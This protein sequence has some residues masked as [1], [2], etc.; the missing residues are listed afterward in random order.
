[1]A[2][3]IPE[4]TI[5]RIK[6]TANIVDLVSE[7]VVLKKAGRNYLGLCPFHAEKTPSFTVNLEKQ[8]FYCFGCH[9]GGNVFSFLMQREGLSFPE[10]VRVLA[11]KYGIEVP[12]ERLTPAQ[13]VQLSEREKLFRINELTMGYYQQALNDPQQG[14]KAMAYLLGRG[15]TRKII[16]SYRLGYAPARWDGLLGFLQSRKVPLPLMQKSGLVVPRKDRS[17]SYDRF[18]NR[19]MFPILNQ[20]QQV[21]GF[22]GRVMG[23]ES[24]KYLNSPETPVYN[25]SRSLYGIDKAKQKTRASG[26]IYLVEGYFDVL[27]LHLYGIDNSVATLGTALTAE[28]VQLLKGLIGQSGQAVLVYDSDQAGIKAAKRSIHVFEEGFL[29][30]H[31]LVLPQGYDPDTF[32]R[33]NGPDDFLRLTERAMGM[34]QFLLESAI[35]EY[36]L[37]LEGKVQIVSQ[38]QQPLAAVQD[39]VARSLYIKQLAERLDIEEA[40]IMERIR[41]TASQPAGNGSPAHS[42]TKKAIMPDEQRLEQQIVAMMLRYPVMIPEI[43]GRNLLHCFEDVNLKA[44]AQMVLER[45]A[46]E[47]D[48]LVDLISAIENP[49]YR[50]LLS[51]LA[52]QETHWDRQGCERLL[53]QL[54]GR[55]LRRSANDLQRQIEVAEKNGDFELL[56]RLLRQKQNQ[57][58]KG[59]TQS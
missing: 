40:V 30:A 37:G 14:Q 39:S 18:R 6:N 49:H 53:V 52:L 43:V 45:S 48:V 10:A 4:D 54:E 38:M 27:A 25:K 31:I 56:G 21:I 28:H 5:R 7:S 9:T 22:G 24:P 2:R 20:S 57:A 26:K 16:D 3:S 58:G 29:N 55:H 35:Q 17:G 34:M 8:I 11:G 41:Q 47:G 59:L 1:M 13:Q 12:Q 50:S 51:R 32:L 19:V 23:D 46:V 44:I 42:V 36:G 33:E 15:M